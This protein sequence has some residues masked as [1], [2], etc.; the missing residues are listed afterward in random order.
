MSE[1]VEQALAEI[2][3]IQPACME[4]FREHGIVFDKVPSTNPAPE[5]L[6]QQVAFSLYTRICEADYIARSALG[7]VSE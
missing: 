6:W 4:M 1:G 5:D 3:E 2:A 7:R